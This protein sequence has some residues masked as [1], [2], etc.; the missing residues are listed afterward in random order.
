[1][2]S[3]EVLSA[4]F[5]SET[6]FVE[7]A[8]EIVNDDNSIEYSG[9]S[10]HPDTLEWWSAVYGTENLD[11][12]IDL[13]LHEPHVENIEPMKMSAT[14]ARAAQK[15]KV[16]NF[17]VAHKPSKSLTRANARVAL[18]QSGL[19]EKFINAA[20]QDPIQVIKGVCPFDPEALEIKRKYIHDLR[21]KN[22]VVNSARPDRV[23]ALRRQ[24]QRPERPAQEDVVPR[25]STGALPTIR[26]E[27]KKKHFKPSEGLGG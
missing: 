17:K 15:N 13:I 6:G 7:V 16:D 9:Q 3:L 18:A 14:E 19:P 20:E 23:E 27:G 4:V 25:K 26:L 10:F 1:M 11:E 12:L 2:K 21:A 5:N 24:L 8:K 22:T